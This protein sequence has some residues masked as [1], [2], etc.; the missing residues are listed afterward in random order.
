MCIRD[1]LY[2]SLCPCKGCSKLIHQA[3]I[4][5][6]VYSEEYKDRSGV[7]FLEKAGIEVCH[8][9]LEG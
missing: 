4:K 3:K 7:E 9:A 6:V 8:I 5:R 2:I 1:R